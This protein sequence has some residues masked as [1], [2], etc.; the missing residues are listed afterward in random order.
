[1]LRMLKFVLWKTESLIMDHS[2]DLLIMSVCYSGEVFSTEGKKQDTTKK[3]FSTWRMQ[4]NACPF[5]HE[6][7]RT[8][9]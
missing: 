2:H 6:D 5:V 9:M 1:M 3:L 4:I 8:V 7:L